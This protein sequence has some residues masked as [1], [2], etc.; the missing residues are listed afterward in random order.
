MPLPP[1]FAGSNATCTTAPRPAWSHWRWISG[2]LG[3]KL[4]D[5]PD[6]AARMV[7]EAHGEV[8]LVLQELRD[9]ARGIHPA[10]L[11]DR[12]LEAA[13]ASLGARCTVPV[14]V[15]VDLPERPALAVEGIVY[16]TTAE[17]LTN[18]SKHSEATNAT[19]EVWRTDADL[20][21]RV[22]DD[23]QGGAD[24]SGG[25]GLAGLAERL[26]AVDGGLAVDSPAG[27]PTTVTA[28][29]PWREHAATPPA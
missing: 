13:L 20:F 7:D 11:T 12:G 25:S 2:S 3:E 15:T 14:T 19:V 26:G 22:A 8:K 21:I 10:I 6:T 29:L 18:I 23:G 17:L 24:P 5:D 1:I 16:F 28:K 9:L 27:G 4:T